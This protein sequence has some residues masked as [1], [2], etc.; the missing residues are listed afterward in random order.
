MRRS[1]DRFTSRVEENNRIMEQLYD[2]PRILEE[3]GHKI[4]IAGLSPFSDY[5]LESPTTAA[6]ASPHFGVKQDDLH[7]NFHDPLVTHCLENQTFYALPMTLDNTMDYFVN[8]SS[9]S[10]SSPL[11]PSPSSAQD[12]FFNLPLLDQDVVADNYDT[13]CINLMTTYQL[14]GN[15]CTP[16]MTGSWF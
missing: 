5:S 15:Q 4:A 11:P 14:L 1:R 12:L 9:E 7:A 13:S 8:N 16:P 2:N 6:S 10:L 3:E